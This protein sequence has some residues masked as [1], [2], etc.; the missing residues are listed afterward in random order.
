MNSQ[1]S[2]KSDNTSKLQSAASE[3]KPIDDV[4]VPSY[5]E[6]RKQC[7]NNTNRN[8]NGSLDQMKEELRDAYM[9]FMELHDKCVLDIPVIKDMAQ[10]V[11]YFRPDTFLLDDP[12]KQAQYRESLLKKISSMPKPE[13]ITYMGD[14]LHRAFCATTADQSRPSVA[15]RN[16]VLHFKRRQYSLQH[17]K[18]KM[19]C[20]WAH[21]C[22]D[23]KSIETGRE[24]VFLYGKLEYSLEQAM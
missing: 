4:H 15:K 7:E 14:E 17:L 2:M 16:L 9:N 1:K 6:L 20:R 8:L 19:L 3:S 13:P 24:A 11:F 12:N 5:A 10:T 22:M 18:Y 21:L 23:S